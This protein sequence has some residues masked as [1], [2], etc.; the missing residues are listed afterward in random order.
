MQPNFYQIKNIRENEQG[1]LLR[2]IAKNFNAD[3]VEGIS[4]YLADSITEWHNIY[5]AKEAAIQSA[6]VMD[7]L[8]IKPNKRLTSV[9]A[10][11]N[12]WV[13]NK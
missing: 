5:S 10:S 3:D 7:T 8:G 2:H 9:L 1:R 13:V 12:E 11:V 4:H 6:K